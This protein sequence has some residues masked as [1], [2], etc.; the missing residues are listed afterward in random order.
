MVSISRQCDPR[1]YPW[2][3]LIKAWVLILSIGLLSAAPGP[4]L[5]TYTVG[6]LPTGQTGL[7]AW[8]TDSSTTTAGATCAS[9]GTYMT[10]CQYNGSAWVVMPLGLG[11][12][13][14][15][16]AAN[17]YPFTSATSVTI[18]HN[19]ATT[20]VVVRCYDSS[21]NQIFPNT[22]QRTDSNTTAVT[23]ANP[24]S[25]ACT[26]LTG[27]SSGQ[28]FSGSFT[29]QTSVALSHNFGTTNVLVGCYDN[30]SPSQAVNP[31]S[32]ALTNSNTV[33]VG[34]LASQTG[35]CVVIT[36]TS[37]TQEYTASFTAQTSLVATHNLNTKNVAA[38]CYD[39][40]SPSQQFV[41]AS[42]TL[43]TSNIVTFSF[44]ASQTGNCI[45]EGIAGAYTVTTGAILAE[46][47]TFSSTPVFSSSIPSS[48]I[49]LTGNISSFTLAAGLDGQQKL[50]AFC[51]DATGSRTVAAPTNV[52]SF[53]TVGSTAS[54]C[55]VQRFIYFNAL[56]FWLADGPGLTNQ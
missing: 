52:H 30:Q 39:N 35:S 29:S 41:P 8:V 3:V 46:T 42:V 11:S 38:S 5:R 31:Q 34:F 2:K 27:G 21:N 56:S 14:T 1:Q 12:S 7:I 24:Q 19:L 20:S 45:I 37:S 4:V 22:I 6:T 53:F 23:F 44:L 47:V 40:Q 50:L 28:T 32:V 18:V 55:S 17:G 26:V 48:L 33:T 36:G 13:G 25:G 51:Q 43:T 9:G 15:T 10:P 49:T 54:K 16:T